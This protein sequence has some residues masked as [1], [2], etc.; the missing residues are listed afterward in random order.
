M[1]NVTKNLFDY[2]NSKDIAAYVTEKP[3]NQIPYFAETLFPAKKQLGT[4]I[5]WLKG[6]NGLPVAIQ[7]SEYDVKARLREKTGFEGVATEMAFFRESTRIGE[8]DRQQLNLLLNNPESQMAMPIIRN[9]FDE[10]A[11][12]VEGVRV[13]GEYMRC[14]LL[15]G[16]KIDV[17]SADG[18]VKYVYDYGQQNL[19][20]CK[21][22]HAAWGEANEAA[23]PVRDINAWC[24]YME[25]LRGIRPTRLVMNRNT[26]LNMIHS[27]KVH[28]MMYPDD[29]ALNYYVTDAKAKSFIEEATGCAIFIYAKKITTLSHDTGIATGDV[30]NLIPDGKVVI[31]PPRASLGSTW[32]GTTPEESDLMTGSDAQVSIVNN[33]TAI[34]TYKETHPVQVVT[35]VSSVMI[36]SFETIDDCAV[37][38]VTQVSTD[39]GT[40]IK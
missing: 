17:A 40:E 11:R 20:K 12:L 18:R 33:G 4:D 14:Q 13:Q 9:I 10:V 2:I 15:T 30:V 6:A 5:S 19:F 8:K 36:P 1:A 21:K 39:S 27:P 29:S 28:K 3:E 25:V 23:D 16:G 31:L 35:V 24:D 32:Y 7:P 22:G 37:A 38:N 34:T 26:F